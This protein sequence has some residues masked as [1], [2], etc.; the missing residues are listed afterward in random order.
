[1]L[2][3]QN[4]ERY[5]T[6]LQNV[7][8]RFTTH[9]G[10]KLKIR[11]MRPGDAPLLVEMFYKLSPETRR[12][13]FHVNVE[14][15]SDAYVEQGAKELAKVDN[16]TLAGAV[17]AVY[18]DAEGEHVV[19][20]VRLARNPSTPDSSEAEA[21]VVVRD[22]FQGQGVATE[23]MRRLV[24]LAKKMCVETIVAVFQPDNEDAIRLFRELNLPYTTEINHGETIMRLKVP[25]ER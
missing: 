22:D 10:T 24:L 2:Y 12:R 21:A 16:N 5:K 9:G 25:L 20:S 13:R 17:I 19:G 6:N 1:M 8:P 4:I 11:L 18:E 7:S 14:K 3:K 23:L 15:L